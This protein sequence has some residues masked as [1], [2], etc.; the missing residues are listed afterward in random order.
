[1]LDRSPAHASPVVLSSVWFLQTEHGCL[2]ASLQTDMLVG[3][4]YS[5]LTLGVRSK[6]RS[7]RGSQGI[8]CNEPVEL[9]A[10]V[11]HNKQQLKA[12]WLPETGV[13]ID[14]SRVF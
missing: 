3:F 2:T 4:D 14:L 6:Y 10:K 8:T 5:R 9:Y 11:C 7:A 1:M 13:R 12:A